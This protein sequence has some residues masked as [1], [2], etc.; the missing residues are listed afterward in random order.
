V[1]KRQAFSPAALAELTD[2]RA[3]TLLYFTADWCITCKVNEKGALA[4]PRVA[5][6]F[7]KAG[8]TVMVGDW[9]RPNPD[10]ARFLEARG[11]AGIPLYLFYGADGTVRELPQILTVDLL[12]NLA[13]PGSSGDV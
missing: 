4:S 6:S 2:R 5:E 7:R 9:T 13:T 11:R 10:I 12:T 8:V 1:Y 3:P